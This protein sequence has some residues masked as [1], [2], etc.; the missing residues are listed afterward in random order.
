MKKPNGP[1]AISQN[2]LK[3]RNTSGKN[4][5]PKSLQYEKAKWN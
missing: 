2:F 5:I 1:L 3:M 4:K